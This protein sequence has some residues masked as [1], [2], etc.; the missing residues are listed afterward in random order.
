[1]CVWEYHIN[2]KFHIS[3]DFPLRYVYQIDRDKAIDWLGTL[4]V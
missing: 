1:M 4:V 3:C 2:Y